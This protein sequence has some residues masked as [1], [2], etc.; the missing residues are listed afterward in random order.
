M[1]LAQRTRLLAQRL[2]ETRAV[3]H[4]VGEQDGAGDR[5]RDRV[6][7]RGDLVRVGVEGRAEAAERGAGD[8]A[9]PQLA[10]LGA[11][12]EV[13]RGDQDPEERAGDVVVPVPGGELG[14]HDEAGE[15]RG[16]RGHR[17]PPADPDHHGHGD[18][19]DDADREVGAL[20][21]GQQEELG[22]PFDEQQ[23][24]Q[25]GVEDPGRE[26]THA[27]DEGAEGLHGRPNLTRARGRFVVRPDDPRVIPEEEAA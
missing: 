5:Q 4:D 20:D 1:A 24:G 13:V 18:H 17:Q 6:D 27:G 25:P 3:A 11:S 16:E 8:H 19:H 15:L 26:G 10:A 12:A 7:E 23:R 22:E 21:R 2:I 9:R 14:H